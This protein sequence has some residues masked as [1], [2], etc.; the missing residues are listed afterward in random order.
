MV[1]KS[2]FRINLNEIE[3]EGEFPCPSCGIIISPDDES[4]IIYDTIEVNTKKDGALK[5]LVILCKKCQS[6]IRLEG[7]EMLEKLEK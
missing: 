1:Q 3:G 6:M 5:E 4:G 2:A 7:F